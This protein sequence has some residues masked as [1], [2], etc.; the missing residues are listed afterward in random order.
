MKYIVY[1]TTNVVNG[2][3]YVGKHKTE[4]PEKFDGYLGNGVWVNDKHSYMFGKEPFCKAVAKYGPKKFQRKILK[5]F[6]TEQEALLFESEIVTEEFIKRA[7]TYNITIGGGQP[8]TRCKIIYQYTLEGGFVKEWNSIIDASLE[9]KC[10]SS[11]IGRAILD[12]TPSCGYLWTDFKCDQLDI[13]KFKIHENQ[14]PIYQYDIN[15]NYIIE[16]S[17]ISECARQLKMSPS[18]IH[19][20]ASGKFCIHKQWW[21][22]YN[23]YN[24]FP[25]PIKEDHKGCAIYQ[26]DLNGN[27]I[28]EW[29]N[30]SEL[31][32]F[33]GRNI[34]VHSAIRLGQICQ[35]YQW[36][37]KK[38]PFMKKISNKSGRRRKVGKYTKEGDLIQEFD[39]IKQAKLDTKSCINALYGRQ[40][41]AGGFIWKFIDN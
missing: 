11:S 17:S 6:E 29:A 13:N 26:Y 41:T 34:N 22:S 27:F 31:K 14:V 5:V 1:L 21:F 9:Y 4:N 18:A 20:S 36:S 8:P 3:I 35:G 32:E 16:Y 37:W 33:Y 30:Y 38:V 28:K 15:G 39:T 7:D 19:K 24:T 40:K 12:S 10:S 23:K 25:I 2:K